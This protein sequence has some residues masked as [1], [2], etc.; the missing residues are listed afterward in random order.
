MSSQFHKNLSLYFS[1]LCI[2]GQVA[3]L[4]CEEY[5]RI[6]ETRISSS[7]ASPNRDPRNIPSVELVEVPLG[8]PSPV[9]NSVYRQTPTLC[10][11]PFKPTKN[12]NSSVKKTSAENT[13]E[14][15]DGSGQNLVV[16]SPLIIEDYRMIW[17]ELYG[18]FLSANHHATERAI[19]DARTTQLLHSMVIP[20][21]TSSIGN[22]VI[23]TSRGGVA[24]YMGPVPVL[25][26][27]KYRLWTAP[28]LLH[29]LRRKAETV[30]PFDDVRRSTMGAATD[31]NIM[32]KTADLVDRAAGQVVERFEALSPK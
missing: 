29:R 21:L 27:L 11:H 12:T 17:Y 24:G 18:R 30:P 19:L 1:P 22:R 25:G 23:K 6:V 9:L 31:M 14:I 16:D 32:S 26:S 8:I 28:L 20:L 5:P 10:I 2:F 15:K 13:R 3:R 7:G 4:F